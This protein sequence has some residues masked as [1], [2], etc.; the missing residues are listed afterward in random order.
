[1][2]RA[3][4]RRRPYK[5]I[6]SRHRVGNKVHFLDISRKSGLS[7]MSPPRTIGYGESL[8]HTLLL[9]D[10]SSTNIANI[11]ISVGNHCNHGRL[12]QF[13]LSL[14]HFACGQFCS[15]TILRLQLP[16]CNSCS[17]QICEY[18]YWVWTTSLALIGPSFFG[19][20][21]SYGALSSG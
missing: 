14:P 10:T 6:E 1:M 3:Q 19:Y 9:I 13:F 12:G 5:S 18:Q 11:V 17:N 21:R 2:K 4:Q 16:L 7:P 15:Q 20:L 8:R